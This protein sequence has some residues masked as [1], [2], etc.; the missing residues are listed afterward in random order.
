[1]PKQFLLL[2][3][4]EVNFQLFDKLKS[5]YPDALNKVKAIEGD[6]SEPNLGK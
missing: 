5:I 2:M 3:Y 1:M 6:V 4:N